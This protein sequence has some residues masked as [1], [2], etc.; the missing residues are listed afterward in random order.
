MSINCS[1]RK[2]WENNV[3]IYHERVYN[4]YNNIV[5]QYSIDK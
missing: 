3:A 4:Y 1:Y 2:V 5:N